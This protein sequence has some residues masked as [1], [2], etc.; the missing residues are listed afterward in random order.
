MEG[1]V[2]LSLCTAAHPLHT[3]V[4]NILG[5]SISEATMR[6][7]PQANGDDAVVLVKGGTVVDALGHVGTRP[8]GDSSPRG[9]WSHSDT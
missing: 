6:P 1:S 7:K 2:A 3:G 8:K 4:A 9:R 5:A